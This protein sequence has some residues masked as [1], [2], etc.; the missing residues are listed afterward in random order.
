MKKNL[1]I[2]LIIQKSEELGLNQTQLGEKVG[3]SKEA[4]SQWLRGESFPRPSKLLRLSQILKLDYNEIL[5]R[6]EE[7]EPVIAFRK[8]QN[9]KTTNDHIKRAKEMG[10]V[11][12]KLVEYLPFETITKPPILNNPKNDYNYIQQTVRI[13]REKLGISEIKVSAKDIIKSFEKF[14]TILIP[15]LLGSKKNHENALHIHLPKSF[16]NWVYINLDTKLFDFK[17]WLVH[18]LGHVFTPTLSGDEAEDFADNFAAAFLFPKEISEKTYFDLKNESKI[19]NRIDHIFNLAQ[20]YVISPYTIQKEVNKFAINT[21]Q[22]E[23]NLGDSFPAQITNFQKK[24]P[25]VSEVWFDKTRPEVDEYLEVVEREFSTVFFDTL[26]KYI[27][28]EKSSPSFIR[29][30][31][32]I[33]IIDSKE[34]YQSLL[35]GIQK[36][37]P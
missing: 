30:I 34:I 28:H 13:L 36:D 22:K 17:F 16:T 26:R 3:V 18:E 8:V 35:N 14:K 6:S 11:L 1:N 9:T 27:S 10:F 20:R 32:N 12:E 29:S 24:F 4:V 31:L 2:P 15:V 23:V 25:L 21:S 33:P 37:T 7:V 5:N 19:K